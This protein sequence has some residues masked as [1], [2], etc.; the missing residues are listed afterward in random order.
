M[1]MG[2]GFM[3]SLDKIKVIHGTPTIRGPKAKA[4]IDQ[5]VP[6]NRN[7]CVESTDEKCVWVLRPP[8]RPEKEFVLTLDEVKHLASKN[9]LWKTYPRRML[10]WNC[11]SEGAQEIYGHVLGD[12]YLTEELEG[13]DPA[14]VKPRSRTTGGKDKPKSKGDKVTKKDILKCLRTEKAKDEDSAMTSQNIRKITGG[15]ADEVRPLLLELHEAE[16]IGKCGE[17]RGT[18]YYIA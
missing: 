8:G 3:E 16:K 18:S 12:L 11:F 1:D 7:E 9:G 10:K 4:L 14:A 13:S 6:E 5:R 15:T 2:M 17:A